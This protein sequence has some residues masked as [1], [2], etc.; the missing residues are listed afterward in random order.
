MT[1]ILISDYESL[2]ETETDKEDKIVSFSN[3]VTVRYDM[4][5]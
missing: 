3:S 1:V 2:F 5:V 4:T